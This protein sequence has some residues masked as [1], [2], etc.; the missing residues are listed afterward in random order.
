MKKL[1]LTIA[2]AGSLGN[3]AFGAAAAVAT[4]EELSPTATSPS[5]A[6]AMTAEGYTMAKIRRC[7]SQHKRSIDL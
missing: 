4:T 6:V 7:R 3:S 2:I 5:A 1:L